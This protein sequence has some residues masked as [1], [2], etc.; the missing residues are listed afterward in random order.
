MSAGNSM[1][2]QRMLTTGT[3]RMPQIASHVVDDE[4]TVIITAWI[5]T[6]PPSGGTTPPTPPPTTGGGGTSA[7]A[8]TEAPSAWGGCGLTGLD[9]LLLLGL[10][11]WV[12]RRRR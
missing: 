2:L 9:G 3:A 7:A 10:A 6:L 1:L 5:N 8:S 11:T 12:R 4:A